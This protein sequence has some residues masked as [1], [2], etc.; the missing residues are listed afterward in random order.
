M[1]LLM[2]G[3]AQEVAMQRHIRWAVEQ[4][5]QVQVASLQIP[6]QVPMLQRLH[7]TKLWPHRAHLINQSRLLKR[8]SQSVCVG[9]LRLR[10]IAHSF[11]PDVVHSFLMGHFT[12]MCLQAGLRPLVVSAWGALNRLMFPGAVD[13]Q[14]YLLRKV[15]AGA[16]V[17]LVENSNLLN[18]LAHFRSEPLLLESFP[19]GVD[20]SLFHPQYQEK[21]AA[22]RFALDIPAEA[23]VVLSPRGWS[24][25][26][27]QTYIMQA[28]AQAHHSLDRPLI[29]V[30]LGLGR[31]KRPETLAQEVLDVGDRL[32]VGHAIR[33]IPWVP[34]HEMP[35][36]YCLS[37]VVVNY[38]ITDAFPSTLLEAA[39]CARPVVT[40]DLP[41]YRN[42]F[43]E[44][45]FRLVEPQNPQA[46]AEALIDVLTT[47]PTL[48]IE[49]MRL[50]RHVVLAEYDENSQRARMVNLYD[51]VARKHT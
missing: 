50:A 19:I 28:F 49:T 47:N 5:I 33:W 8:S 27:G 7:L 14:R 3:P 42:T 41:A 18:A 1:R 37:D 36:I 11:R 20:N 43:V 10:A 25:L 21:A 35:G 22:W 39:A 38:P 24:A 4:G 23:S 16:D 6:E 32:G 31:T 40:C 9:A 45:F 15:R 48:W 2:V 30:L 26:Y 44:R 29:L 34:H 13:K 51:K 17:L 46:L 12:D